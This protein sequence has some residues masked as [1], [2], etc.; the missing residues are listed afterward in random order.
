MYMTHDFWKDQK[1]CP[2][3]QND[4][5]ARCTAC[6][7]LCPRSTHL[8]LCLDMHHDIGRGPFTPSELVYDCPLHACYAVLV[9]GRTCQALFFEAAKGNVQGFC[10]CV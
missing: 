10:H 4:G 2:A 7:R 9:C 8:S 6:Q 1:S 5:T 3:H